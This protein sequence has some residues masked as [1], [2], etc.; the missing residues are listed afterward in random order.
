[1]SFDADQINKILPRL[2]G[3]PAEPTYE[4]RGGSMIT[5]NDPHERQITREDA[6]AELIEDAACRL[7]QSDMQLIAIKH[8]LEMMDDEELGYFYKERLG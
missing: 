2:L 4:H 7:D 1:M 3:Y 6:I 5:V 8:E